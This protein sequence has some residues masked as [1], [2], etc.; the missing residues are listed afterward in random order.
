MTTKPVFLRKGIFDA[1]FPYMGA[2]KRT[3]LSEASSDFGQLR[4]YL[5]IYHTMW[6]IGVILAMNMELN[7]SRIV[8][9][10]GAGF[11]K[12]FGGFLAKEMWENIFSHQAIQENDILRQAMVSDP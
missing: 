5:R 1:Y 9:L 8:I 2:M 12:D 3:I 4:M 11:S 6:W 10:T 7:P